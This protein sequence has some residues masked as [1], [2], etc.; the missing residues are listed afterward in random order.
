MVPDAH[1]E[2]VCAEADLDDFWGMQ[3]RYSIVILGTSLITFKVLRHVQTY[4]S[5]ILKSQKLSQDIFQIYAL[6]PK[7]PLNCTSGVHTEVRLLDL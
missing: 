1:L 3:G 2:A 7:C 4:C 5:L 6:N